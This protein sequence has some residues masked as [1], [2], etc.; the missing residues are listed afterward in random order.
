MAVP[1]VS[2]QADGVFVSDRD[3]IRVF[4]DCRGV[5]CDSDHL[6]REIRFVTWVRDPRDGDVHVIVTSRIAGGD[7]RELD[8][9][10]VGARRRAGVDL[11]LQ[12][13]AARD[14]TAEEIRAA[15]T[16]AMAVGLAALSVGTSAGEDLQVVARTGALPTRP[17]ETRGAHHDP[18]RA[19][20]FRVGVS[21]SVDG[22]ES[23][24]S[25]S[26]VGSVSATHTRPRLSG[27]LRTR[28]GRHVCRENPDTGCTTRPDRQGEVGRVSLGTAP[29]GS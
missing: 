22:E 24:G 15:L 21:G 25:S 1:S 14:A 9:R 28:S 26:F 6:R 27:Q 11:N 3:P 20:V 4:L 5:G 16:R 23:V 8:L 17:P 18:W 7:G 12:R 10:F 13:L 19:W 29:G 2:A